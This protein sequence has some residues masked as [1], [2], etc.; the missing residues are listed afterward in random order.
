MSLTFVTK[1]GPVELGHG[2]DNEG[3][4]EL[5][6][7]VEVFGAD[8]VRRR[9]TREDV[10]LLHGLLEVALEEEPPPPQEVPC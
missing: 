8:G 2:F 10:E 4:L 7:P 6:F 3:L 1:D 9:M 5:R